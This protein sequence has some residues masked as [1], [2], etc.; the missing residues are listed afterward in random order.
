[1]VTLMVGQGVR[2]K[3]RIVFNGGYLASHVLYVHVHAF[4]R[5]VEL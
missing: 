4:E 1:M 3:Q 2:K 5:V